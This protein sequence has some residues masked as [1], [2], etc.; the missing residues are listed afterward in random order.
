M[1][2]AAGHIELGDGRAVLTPARHRP[3]STELPAV[4]ADVLD[5]C[6][7]ERIVVALNIQRRLEVH[8]EDVLVSQI[9]GQLSQVLD[10]SLSN[11]RTDLVPL[12]ASAVFQIE[13]R[14]GIDVHH[15]ATFRQAGNI[16]L[17]LLDVS[18]EIPYGVA[19]LQLA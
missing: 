8:A 17:V 10:K 11:R 19:V 5:V 3:V 15:A 13:R 9:R 2:A 12:A 18:R 6:L 16:G 1:C 14:E 4:E 7:H